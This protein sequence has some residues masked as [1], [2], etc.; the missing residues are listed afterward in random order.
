[1]TIPEN[2]NIETLRAALVAW[3]AYEDR[4]GPTLHHGRELVAAARAV[5]D[6][7]D[8]HVAYVKFVTEQR[9]TPED[10]ASLMKQM[11]PRAPVAHTPADAAP[12]MR[13]KCICPLSPYPPKST[14]AY[15]GHRTE[16]LPW[17]LDWALP[18]W[19]TEL[20]HADY[21]GRTWTVIDDR[22]DTAP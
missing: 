14:C 19:D 1:M 9:V 8:Q 4:F 22:E 20:S 6:E 21:Q 2:P 10:A 16:R 3:D 12:V 5:V 7:F 15:H 13:P 17:P 11:M 18:A